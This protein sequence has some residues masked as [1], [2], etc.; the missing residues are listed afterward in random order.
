MALNKTKE[1]RYATIASDTSEMVLVGTPVVFE[2]PTT[3][4]MEDGGS[5]IEII[6][7]GALD[8]CDLTD[9]TL[10][11][12]H[13]DAMVPLART[14]KTMTLEITDQGLLMRAKL[15][16][17]NPTALATYSAVK[18]GDLAGMSFAFVV[19][20]N[21][22]SYDPDTNTRHITA[23][24]KILECSI[25]EHPAYP[26][27]SVEARAAITASRDESR[28]HAAAR[29]KRIAT[30]ARAKRIINHQEIGQ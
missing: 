18:R 29:A 15:A 5:Y 11:V 6:H 3:I 27:A 20:E 21:G 4:Y 9:S 19:A 13:D 7:R 8:Q 16:G 25:V 12:N 14:P 2:Q 28:A 26:A 24:A 30:L 17:D 10:K 1:L 23:I 22:S